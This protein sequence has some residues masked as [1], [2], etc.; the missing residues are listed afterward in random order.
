MV[1]PVRQSHRLRLI[2]FLVLL[3]PVAVWLGQQVTWK[4]KEIAS[5][6]STAARQN[7]FLAA[8]YFLHQH[9]IDSQMLR[10][11]SLLDG[12]QWQE[13]KLKPDDTLVLFNSYKL[14][15]GKRLQNLLTWVENGGMVIVST[16]N[17]FIGN[18]TRTRD[19]LFDQL[20]VEVLRK[21]SVIDDEETE[22]AADDKTSAEDESASPEDE[23]T[24]PEDETRSAEDKT[25]SAEENEERHRC[26]LDG[27]LTPLDFYGETEP[28]LIDFSQG[29]QFTSSTATVAEVG[30][31]V[32]LY[33]A[34]F[35]YGQGWIVVHSDPSI[36]TNSRIDCHD[37]AYAL[38]NTIHPTNKVWF[39]VNQEAPSLWT[40]LWRASPMGIVAGVLALLLWLWAKAARFGPILTRTETGRRSLAEHIRASATLLWRRQQHPHLITQL[41]RRLCEQV[42]RTHPQFSNLSEPEQIQLLQSLT[43]LSAELIHKGLFADQ[44]QSP[45]DFTE[46]VAHLQ[47]IRKHL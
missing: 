11:F 9:N 1:K 15:Q 31:D 34:V 18:N 23:T 32:G 26:D 21:P 8:Q 46:T 44:V 37:H 5:S 47:T 24:S 13:E 27:E 4:E 45:Q 22:T 35:E 10:S 20:N 41:R 43:G 2:L 28:L 17:R 6:Q 30:D 12:L 3:V 19:P 16:S 25:K 14:L 29:E 38:W 42:Q 33:Q 7:S 39:L 36:W 40:L